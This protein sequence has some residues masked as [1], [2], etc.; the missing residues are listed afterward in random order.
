MEQRVLGKNAVRPLGELKK[1]TP[2]VFKVTKKNSPEDY[3]E[4]C[5]TFSKNKTGSITTRMEFEVFWFPSK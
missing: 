4:H 1:A 3:S 2:G 5:N